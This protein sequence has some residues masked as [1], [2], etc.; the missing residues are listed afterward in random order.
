MN[1]D[2]NKEYVLVEKDKLSCLL[3]SFRALQIQVIQL[4]NIIKE[5]V[6]LGLK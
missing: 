1:I 2:N 3:D 4:E 6:K 5:D